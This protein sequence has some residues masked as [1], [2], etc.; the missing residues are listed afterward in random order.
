MPHKVLHVVLNTGPT[1]M[2]FNEFHKPTANSSECLSFE[3]STLALYTANR[4]I[5]YFLKESK[6]LTKQFD[7]VH[8]H[9]HV[10]AFLFIV[11]L[12]FS[13]PK[14]LTKCIYTVHT[15]RSNLSFKNFVFF[16][17]A[18]SLCRATVC[19]SYSSYMSFNAIIR[20]LFRNKLAF[21]TNGVDIMEGDHSYCSTSKPQI[22][23]VGRLIL[24]K[25]PLIVVS[26]LKTLKSEF[27]CKIIGDGPLLEALREDVKGDNRF[28]FTGLIPRV[29]VNNSLFDAN[30]FISA[31]SVEGMPV[32]A[33]E[34][35]S[36]GCYLILSNI[37]PHIEIAERIPFCDIFDSEEELVEKVESLLV[38]SNSYFE[39]VFKKNRLASFQN[40]SIN[41]MLNNYQLTYQ[42]IKPI[43]E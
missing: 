43:Y 32:A 2:G 17:I 3:S 33:I 28:S 22:I 11:G 37:K 18:L 19:C 25:R 10:L 30:I 7:I 40:F 42:R 27:D 6:R 23:S 34:A 14:G 5:A 31:S 12:L 4:K 24:L 13:Y 35:A 21:I 38:K 39:N 26:S 36:S 29:D 1:N 9:S 41:K 8:F 16:L 15:S 20:N